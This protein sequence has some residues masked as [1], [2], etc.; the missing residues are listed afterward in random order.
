MSDVKKWY[1]DFDNATRL[2]LDAAE[3][4]VASERREKELQQRL[5]AADERADSAI[6]FV[7]R[8][9]ESAGA[10]PSIATGYLRDILDTLKPA[11]GRSDE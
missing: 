3:R 7:T 5:T 1:E 8:L 6:A 9:I 11:E 10:Q 4:C 2:F